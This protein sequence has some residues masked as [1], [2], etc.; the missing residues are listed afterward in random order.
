MSEMTVSIGL[1]LLRSETCH[2]S[3][4]FPLNWSCQSNYEKDR[5]SFQTWKAWDNTINVC[6]SDILCEKIGFEISSW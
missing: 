5:K 1:I 2:H 6:D 3:Y 4:R